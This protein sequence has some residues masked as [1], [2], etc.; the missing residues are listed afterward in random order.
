MIGIFTKLRLFLKYN[1]KIATLNI[2]KI[3]F[4]CCKSSD[5]AKTYLDKSQIIH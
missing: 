2:K 3:N 1:A 5:C 4:L